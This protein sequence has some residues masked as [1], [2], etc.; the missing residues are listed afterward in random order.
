MNYLNELLK[1]GSALCDIIVLDAGKEYLKPFNKWHI[2]Y[3]HLQGH[4][5]SQ[6]PHVNRLSAT[7]T[8]THTL[9]KKLLTL[10][11][12]ELFLKFSHIPDWTDRGRT[13]RRWICPGP[14]LFYPEQ[15]L[16]IKN[17]HMKISILYHIKHYN[18]VK[19]ANYSV[20]SF[21]GYIFLGDNRW[22]NCFVKRISIIKQLFSEL[23]LCRILQREIQ[24][25][26]TQ[27]NI[28]QVLR[29]DRNLM[30]YI[31]KQWWAFKIAVQVLNQ[32]QALS[33]HLV[34]VLQGRHLPKTKW[35]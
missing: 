10:N 34:V 27:K 30:S 16:I 33:F 12:W 5:A 24:P 4:W 8:Y 9:S 2:C 7:H 18:H 32:I 28:P 20:T 22:I 26:K 14:L 1:V 11:Q 23:F 19:H 13:A 6:Q 17:S 29:M 21:L 31:R 25:F 35:R 15:Q 3:V